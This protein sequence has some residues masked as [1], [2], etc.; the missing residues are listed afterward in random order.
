MSKIIAFSGGMFSGKSS[1]IVAL[2]SVVSMYQTV[3]NIKFAQPLYDIQS[4]IYQRIDR[5]VPEPKDRKLLQ[6][7]GTDW[8][9]SITENLWVDIWQEEVEAS[10]ASIITCDDLRFP[11]EAERVRALGGV[12]VRVIAPEETRKARAAALG[13]TISSHASEVPLP[14]E[15]VDFELFNEGSPADLALL[16]KQLLKEIGV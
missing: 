9:R 10:L 11:N 8:G 16:V 5:Q 3:E 15:L 2:E 14:N 7:L 12:I 1:A 6:W 13:M 4:Y